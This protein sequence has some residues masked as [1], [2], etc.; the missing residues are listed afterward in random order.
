MRIRAK[1]LSLDFFAATMGLAAAGCSSTQ[2]NHPQPPSPQGQSQSAEAPPFAY[3]PFN[4]L[5]KTTA[6]YSVVGRDAATMAAGVVDGARTE[7]GDAYKTQS[8]SQI[9]ALI[10]AP[11]TD[12]ATREKII[13]GGVKGLAKI[14][15]PHDAYM[16]EAEVE[17]LWRGSPKV[18]GIGISFEVDDKAGGLL[19]F[20]MADGGPASKA[21]L[22]IG[23]II[24]A[25]DGKPVAGLK[26]KQARAMIVGD[27]GTPVSM[28]VRRMG[29]DT[30]QTITIMRDSYKYT[31]TSARAM[32][33]IAYVRLRDFSS[34]GSA[35][36]V[37]NAMA[38]LEQSIGP[39]KI[40]G[41]ILDLRGNPGGLVQEARI[42]V[43][44]FVDKAG[45]PSV[46]VRARN[47]TYSE[48]THL[49]DALE[50]KPL[51]VLIND[52]SASA[53]EIVSGALQ[54]HQRATVLGTQSYGKGSVQTRISLGR[55]WP[56]RHDAMKVTSAMYYLPSG[57]SIQNIGITPDILVE[58]VTPLLQEHERDLTNVLANPNGTAK[59][60]RR[61]SAHCMLKNAVAA[62]DLNA[63]FRDYRG[64]PDRTLLCALDHLRRTETHTRTRTLPAPGR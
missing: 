58:D 55:V 38:G 53:A 15:S 63:D 56:E 41:Y 47:Y 3:A 24:T 31:P 50:G 54:D 17:Q 49:G 45:A 11:G 20:D 60:V 9:R 61:F 10:D 18:T 25:V 36:A 12:A 57:A 37:V 1:T 43:D 35:G 34:R 29:T 2:P 19:I 52:G 22:R 4:E 27:K 42:L 33:D 44:A 64:Q 13:V 7:L 40:K 14:L 8:D 32:G 21:G 6:Y 16:T 5:L 48:K 26:T 62:N 23:D 30:V 59:P 39:D 51:T 46:E 28:T